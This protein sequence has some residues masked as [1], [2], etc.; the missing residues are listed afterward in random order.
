MQ[1]CVKMCD[2]LHMRVTAKPTVYLFK[3]DN[4]SYYGV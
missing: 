2:I 1:I 4:G 3:T